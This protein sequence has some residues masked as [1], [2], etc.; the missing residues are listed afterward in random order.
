MATEEVEVTTNEATAR[1]WRLLHMMFVCWN[2]EPIEGAMY[3]WCGCGPGWNKE[4]GE[5][6]RREG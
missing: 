5:A 3:V 1:F 4:T 6:Y 2:V